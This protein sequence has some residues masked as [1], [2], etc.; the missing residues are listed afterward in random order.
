MFV[1]TLENCSR[2]P[3]HIPGKVQDHGFLI[4]IDGTFRITY[5]SENVV[6]F[7]GIP[8]TALLNQPAGVLDSYLRRT[9]PPNF[10]IQL[11]KLA[12]SDK[13]FE[14][15]NPY[16][17]T[18]GGLPFNLIISRSEQFYL[19]EF[20][21]EIS[22]L[23]AEL[24]RIVGRS[25]SEMLSDIQ[26]SSILNKS[27]SKIKEVIGYDRVMIYKFHADGHGEVVA[28]VKNDNL[29][30][31]LGLHYPATD[32][33]KQ[34]R[35][36]YK[37]NLT[38][39]ISNVYTTPSA[40]VT[41]L[42]MDKAPLDLTNSA[43]R[44]VSPI[45]IQYLK[46]MG[47]A[48]SFSISL[49][50]EDELWGLIACHNYTPRFINYKERDA[51]KL[52][53]QVLSSALSFRILE[54][55]EQN[56]ARF[57]VATD[58]LTRQ[59]IRE[60]NI[61]DALFKYECTL[62]DAVDATGV[63]MF[64]D[65]E[66]HTKG[67]V[68]ELAFLN[69]LIDWLDENMEPDIYA[70][71][72]LSEIYPDAIQYKEIGSGML[73]CRLSRELG[74][75]MIWFRP[76]VITTVNWAGNPDKAVEFT[77]NDLMDISPRKSFEIWSDEVHLT[78]VPWLNEEL[79]SALQ[80]KE[81]IRFAISRKATE[82]RVLNEKLK[83]AYDELD[84]FSYTIS[85]DLKN[86]LSSIKS[87]SQILL[88]NFTLEPKAQHMVS[89][90]L[91]GAEKMQSM[92]QDVL[93]YSKAGQGQSE[94]KLVN[95]ENL[96]NELKQELLISYNDTDVEININGVEDIYGEETMVMQVF[97]NLIGNAVKY[98]KQASN[99]VVNINAKDYG[100]EVEY[101]IQDNGIGID[102]AEQDKI[103][104][105]FTRA[106]DVSAFEGTGVGLSIVK[107]IMAKHQGKVWVDSEI[108][109]GSTFFVRFKKPE[110]A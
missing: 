96:L 42:E 35:E 43:L 110:L 94:Y 92:I 85:H 13:G 107:K 55:D 67:N 20:E 89:R 46:N 54:Q 77:G 5:C 25:L 24:Q 50:H 109:K 40:I 53:G 18:I 17:L 38:R 8:A 86:P 79:Q 84:A 31:F 29:E 82:L 87:Y 36:L 98:S 58:V 90:I 99:P 93:S 101:A 66:L 72:K 78:A 9:E 74:E 32:I 52:I 22:D 34:A 49:V 28:E 75:Y 91:T 68:P 12:Q 81:E 4:A 16:P 44:A 37:K 100:N 10:I 56:A 71:Q 30:P 62:L 19:L 108:N 63:A 45:H 48:S 95:M 80:L 76:E 14:P 15:F 59:L 73:A 106:N 104:E 69:N 64:F 41:M 65:N 103:F 102:P 60:N 105:L 83:E 11:I 33:P 6:N 88:R 26:P 27:V 97:S 1:P 51:A 23:K 70:T 57:K 61:L 2:E 39:L 7:F 21:P 47:V 3:I